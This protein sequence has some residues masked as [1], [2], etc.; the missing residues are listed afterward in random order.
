MRTPTFEELAG[1]EAEFFANHFN[2]TPLLRRAALSGDSRD[3]LSVADLD[4]LLH[5]EAIRP[6]Y[7]AIT[8]DGDG[9]PER[10]YTT[11]TRVQGTT[12]TDTVVAER[13]YELF[14]TGATLTWSSLNH[15]LPSVRALTRMLA[16][17]FAARS[18]VV[19]FLT[20]AGR[21][22][23]SPH[24]DPVD[25]FII[26]LEGTKHWK[27]WEP[28]ATRRGDIG[29]YKLEELGTPVIETTLQAGDVLY[30][31]YNT[32]HVAAAEDQVSLHLSVMVRPRM[33]RDLLGLAVERLLDTE[34][35]W[36]FPYLH[37]S[38]VTDLVPAF[39]DHA[40]LLAERLRE[41]DV[42]AE[43]RRLMT[44]GQ[45]SEGTAQGNEFQTIAALDA[46]GGSTLLRRTD[47]AVTFQESQDGRTKTKVNG[48]TIAIPS[49]VAAT[50]ARM[51]S[52][53]SVPAREI[54]PDVETARSVGIAQALA[55]LGVLTV[56]R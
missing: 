5:L 30:L 32:P 36:Q 31:P 50:L 20:P 2:Q 56:A 12:V 34:G 45:H 4:E 53:E 35:F 14:R 27:L 39:T 11:L 55:R 44:L 41:I 23:F 25:L 19:A 17:K 29:H 54:N 33:W 1:D 16:T 18:D 9:V 38:T 13:V 42:E 40:A 51:T 52:G 28:P 3:V 47:V 46:I 21:Q 26:Q 8:K 49:A 7:L 6:P 15:V 43:L 22:G 48:H 10:A 37:E 24:H